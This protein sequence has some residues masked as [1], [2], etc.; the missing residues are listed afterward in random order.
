MFVEI[1]EYSRFSRFVLTLILSVLCLMNKVKLAT[2]V[3]RLHTQVVS[4]ARLI[5]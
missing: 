2:Q 1:T 5:T 4:T 3:H